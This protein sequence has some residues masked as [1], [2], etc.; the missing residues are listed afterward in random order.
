MNNWDVYSITNY[1][2]NKHQTGNAFSPEEFELMYNH[3]SLK[4]FKRRLGMPEEYQLQTKY[5]QMGYADTTR[6]L[7]DLADFVVIKDNPGLKFTGGKTSIPSDML[8]PLGMTYKKP[9]VGAT[10]ET[11]Y[12]LRNVELIDGGE[13]TMRIVSMLKPINGEYPIYEFSGNDILI[14]PKEIQYTDF[15]YLRK[16]T[17][18]VF[19]TTTNATTGEIEYDA[20][21][22]VESEWND[23]AKVDIITLLLGSAGLNLR[24]NEIL[25]VAESIKTKGI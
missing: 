3:S 4:L 22:S 21:K 6:I 9:I 17:D 14:F 8:Y 20:S 13:H 25:Q 16:P 12:D 19:A 18:I 11:D 24:S 2:I 7:T 5:T 10:C 1:L 15:V 23:L